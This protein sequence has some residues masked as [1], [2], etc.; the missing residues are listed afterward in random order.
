MEMYPVFTEKLTGSVLSV[1]PDHVLARH[2]RLVATVEKAKAR[3][4]IY[5]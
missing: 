2:F 5:G 1:D 4:S 3:L